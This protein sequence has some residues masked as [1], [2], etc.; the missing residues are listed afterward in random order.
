MTGD[1]M[2]ERPS[3]LF[4]VSPDWVQLV[5]DEESLTVVELDDAVV[6]RAPW[7][8]FPVQVA[9]A[10]AVQDPDPTGQPYDEEHEQLRAYEE[11]LVVALGQQGRLVASIT[12]DGVRELVGYLRAPA[13][14]E[15]WEHDPPEGVGSHEAVVT[16]MDDPGWLGLREIAGLLGE[17]EESLRPP[18]RSPPDG[19]PPD[20][21]PPD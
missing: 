5:D 15:A 18:D 6:E 11:H 13:V 10:L 21:G 8:G 17:D 4:D 19:S 7:A 14:V 16:L 20:G 1:P 2:T 3:D 12:M 9:I